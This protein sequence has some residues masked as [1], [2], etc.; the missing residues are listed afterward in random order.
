M[1]AINIT[2]AS[3]VNTTQLEDLT[4]IIKYSTGEIYRGSLNDNGQFHGYGEFI[5]PYDQ[6]YKGGFKNGLKHGWCIE[7][8]WNNC[9]F[10]GSYEDGKREGKGTEKFKD[11]DELCLNYVNDKRHGP[12]QLKSRG[13]NEWKSFY[14]YYNGEIETMKKE[15]SYLKEFSEFTSFNV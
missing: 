4:V 12:S 3:I 5:R 9:I 13:D 15:N 8:S 2:M 7:Q 14:T 1:T 11:G 10:E 6:Y